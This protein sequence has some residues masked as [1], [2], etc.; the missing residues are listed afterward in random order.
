MEGK[1]DN[2]VI[3]LKPII[4]DY[5][6]HW[7]LI[8]GVGLFAVIVAILYLIFYPKTYETMA[9]VQIRDGNN[10]MMGGGGLALGEAAG[11]MKSFGL[12]GLGGGGINI[13]D[14][15]AAFTSNS[16]LSQMAYKLGIYVEYSEPWTFHYKLYEDNPLVVTSDSTQIA[17]L[18]NIIEFDV[19][20]SE[21]QVKIKTEIESKKFKQTYQFASLPATVSLP[22]GDFVFN[23]TDIGRNYPYFR[24]LVTVNPLTVT[25][26]ELVNELL[27]EDISKTAN[28]IEFTTRDYKKQRSKDIFNTLIKLYNERETEFSRDLGLKSLVFLDDRIYTL[29]ND[30]AE[31]EKSIET[32]KTKNNITSVDV[33]V[34][35]YTEYIKELQMKLIEAESQMHLVKMLDAFVKDST[36]RYKL[37]PSLFSS[38]GTLGGQ[39]T[40]VSP[41]A[42]YNQTLLERERIIKN[43][44]IDNPMVST[45]NVQIDRLRESVYQMIDNAYKSLQ[46][47]IDELKSKEEVMRVRMGKVP[48]QE[49]TYIDYR[50]QQEILQGVYLLLLQKREEILLSIGQPTDKAKT[51]DAAFTKPRP[52]APRKLFA[53]IGIIVFTLVI[54]VG[55]LFGKEQVSGLYKDLRC[56][57]NQR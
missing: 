50:R 19:S 29:L 33:D 48:G 3:G 34:Q 6:L 55:W 35:Y 27:I 9:R 23:Y 2:E 57:K 45:L 56:A 43:S 31:V 38:G 22:Q 26:D 24:L 32:F 7:K 36:N 42:I 4:I 39:E 44:G 18:D 13:E 46:L 8:I 25:S 37:A 11:L 28:V 10:P 41:L 15:I 14:E 52:V 40:D 20:I 5:L 54:T 17:H 12:G 47:F 53:V 30:L 49:R 21:K 51:V 16:L 1:K